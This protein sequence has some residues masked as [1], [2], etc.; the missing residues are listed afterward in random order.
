MNT[1]VFNAEVHPLGE[2]A[3]SNHLVNENSNG[4]GCDVRDD[5]SSSIKLISATV[6]LITVPCSNRSWHL[7]MEERTRGSICGACPFAGQ[8]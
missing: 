6:H 4:A 5:A 2:V 7:C 1:Y 8:R 3:V